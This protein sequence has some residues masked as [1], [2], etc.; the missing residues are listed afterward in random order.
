MCITFKIGCN[1]ALEFLKK[2]RKLSATQKDE[3]KS[4]IQDR[5]SNKKQKE[6]ANA[7]DDNIILAGESSGSSM[8]DSANCVQVFE[9]VYNTFSEY[10]QGLNIPKVG[11]V[12]NITEELVSICEEK[13]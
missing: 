13:A 4:Q 7:V 12:Q 9:R 8:V 3:K 2:K 10:V 6:S 1:Q 11:S 5:I